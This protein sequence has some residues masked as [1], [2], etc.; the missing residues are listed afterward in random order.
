MNKNDLTLKIQTDENI[1]I[2]FNCENFKESNMESICL[3]KDNN[4]LGSVV[5]FEDS[6]DNSIY[7][8]Y[9]DIDKEY[10]RL[11]YGSFMLN[12]L[13]FTFKECGFSCIHGECKNELIP[14]YKFVGGKIENR[15]EDDYT[16]LNNR[17]YIDLN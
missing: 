7:I 3:L 12:C 2:D 15:C 17:F 16:Y 11:G 6:S 14:F 4:I 8:E 10:R 5:L 9:L 13:K 1:L